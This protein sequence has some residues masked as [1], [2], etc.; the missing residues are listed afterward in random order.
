MSE[1][2]T[3]PI[4]VVSSLTGL[5]THVL[6]AWERRYRA[7]APQRS[8]SGRRLYARDDIDR[9]I[10]LKRVVQGGHGISHV[11]G[12]E[13]TQLAELAALG[14]ADPVADAAPAD[15][16]AD[17]L[18]IRFRTSINDCLQ[19]VGA[20]DGW[21]LQRML[22][23]MAASC[24]RQ[25]FLEAVIRPLMTEVGHRWADGA[26]RI[27]HGQLASTVVLIMLAGWLDDPAGGRA[28]RPRMLIATP[29][30]QRCYLGAL[31]AAVTAQ[32]CG[33][34]PVFVGSDLP[35][36]EIVA[37]QARV[38]PQI[39]ALSITCQLD[40]GG[41]ADAIERLAATLNPSSELIVGGRAS[42][43]YLEKIEAVGATL[44]STTADLAR[45]IT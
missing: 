20:L 24:S 43:P 27:V 44:C 40:A 7:V 26:F 15:S 4:G 35:T 2:V 16:H 39:T 28:D 6:R 14:A 11:A 31:A 1:S 22:T 36:E 21:H 25:S 42:Q 30:G 13:T 8:A 37:A 32:D 23:G 34:L 17:D 29:A 18:P 5:S 12:L 38:A 33:W 41:T 19:A 10:L 45:R 9:L 3:Y